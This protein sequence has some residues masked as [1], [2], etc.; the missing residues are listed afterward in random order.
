M[1]LTSCARA[2]KSDA[3]TNASRSEG[4]PGVGECEQRWGN[5]GLQQQNVSRIGAL[6]GEVAECEPAWGNVSR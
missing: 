6:S 5:G 2:P 3:T 4:M 1:I